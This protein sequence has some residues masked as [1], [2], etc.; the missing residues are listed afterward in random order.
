MKNAR[1][2]T[3]EF[4]LAYYRYLSKWNNSA[5]LASMIK[6]TDELLGLDNVEDSVMF[7]LESVANFEWLD[8]K[9]NFSNGEEVMSL[10]DFYNLAVSIS[11]DKK[12][13]D[14]LN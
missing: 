2:L 10:L 11:R 7:D 9:D 1:K 14:I 13:N 5:S 3:I 12:I 4:V 6:H 8:T